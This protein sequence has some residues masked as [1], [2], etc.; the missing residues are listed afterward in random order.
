MIMNSFNKWHDMFMFLAW[1]TR[2]EV[3]ILQI[4]LGK[5][6]TTSLILSLSGR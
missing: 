4:R 2:K 5:T 3:F 6:I 1:K